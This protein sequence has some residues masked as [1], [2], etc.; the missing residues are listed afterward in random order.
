MMR[1]ELSLSRRSPLR[2]VEAD[3]N[4]ASNV[5]GRCFPLMLSSFETLQ[6]FTH[7]VAPRDSETLRN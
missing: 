6:P 3:F 7:N 1:I 5:L 4:L 2:L